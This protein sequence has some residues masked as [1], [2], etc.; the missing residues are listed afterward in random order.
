MNSDVVELRQKVEH[1]LDLSGHAPR[2]THAESKRD[3]AE[4]IAALSAAD[5][6][7]GIESATRQGDAP[8]QPK[9]D[10]S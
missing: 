4:I 1:L 10:P 3:A 6:W 5:E 7:Q 2:S 8:T 9:G